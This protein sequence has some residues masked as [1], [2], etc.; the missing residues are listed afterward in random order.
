MNNYTFITLAAE[1]K[2]GLFDFGPTLP[3]IVIQFLVLLF[4]L[5]I[6]LYNPLI[7]LLEKRASNIVSQLT[8]ASEILA[9]GNDL[10]ESYNNTL[11]TARTQSKE[12]IALLDQEQSKLYDATLIKAKSDLNGV[13]TDVTDDIKYS[14]LDT[15]KSLLLPETVRP[16]SQVF[17]EILFL[18]LALPIP[19]NGRSWV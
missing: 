3:L 16:L 1:E 19:P 10:I 14:Q 4:V 7:T 17:M 5:N 8:A 15:F 13:V 11:K 18:N 2:G 6:I 12:N 9:T